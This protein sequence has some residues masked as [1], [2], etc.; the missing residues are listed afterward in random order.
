MDNSISCDPSFDGLKQRYWD[1]EQA[2][3]DRSDLPVPQPSPLE[4]FIYWV[5][6][7]ALRYY[8]KAQ[9]QKAEVR[10]LRRSLAFDPEWYLARNPDVAAQNVNPAVH[11]VKH[12]ES[13]G[14]PP[15]PLFVVDVRKVREFQRR[16]FRQ[17]Y[18]VA[19]LKRWHSAYQI[20]RPA[21]TA[22]PLP[23][24]AISIFAEHPAK[25]V[26]GLTHVLFVGHEASK[27]GAPIA[28]KN[29]MAAMVK[30][31]R[32]QP[33]FVADADGPL[34]D[35]YK[36]LAPSIRLSDCQPASNF[37][38]SFISALAKWCLRLEGPKIAICNTVVAADY[39]RQ[40]HGAGIPVITWIH[41]L[42]T[43]ITRF[44]GGAQ[45]MK[46]ITSSSRQIVYVSESVQRANNAAFGL[47]PD[48]GKVIHNGVM[49]SQ[50]RDTQFRQRLADELTIPVTA[51]LV[52]GCGTID[53]RKGPDLFVQVA[54]KVH[55]SLKKQGWLAEPPHFVWL[56]AGVE[57]EWHAWCCHDAERL[58]VGRHVHFPGVRNDLPDFY[59]HSRAFLLTSREDPFPLVT[60]E[61]M[62][63]GL[64]VVAF[65]GATGQGIL[66]ERCGVV[67]PYLDTG[68]M[69]DAVNK[70]LLVP[71]RQ[72]EIG[73]AASRH[74]LENYS[75]D[76]CAQEFLGEIDHILA[77]RQERLGS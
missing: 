54:H 33:W 18:W 65:A 49:I 71:R 72:A 4:K 30:T 45:T 21:H 67:V 58:G 44:G 74:V 52:M 27:T 39:A 36:A 16:N 3:L 2:V 5:T 53:G 37:R 14:R 51:P 50:N 34:F 59:R 61:A 63:Y 26:P 9:S 1:L 23:P 19:Y 15:S 29:L 73:Q 62:G 25:S 46:T 69:A 57:K 64:P 31:K 42:P 55:S 75:W 35:E 47:D 66:L 24:A 43:S 17:C 38:N 70:L 32:I 8:L 7:I 12:G 76:K 77:P 11:Y 28:L 56:G 20:G 40:L 10:Y 41:E 22:K 13:E 60:M 48:F 6:P 68:A